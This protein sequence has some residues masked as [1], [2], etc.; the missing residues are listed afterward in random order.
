YA[1]ALSVAGIVAGC[2]PAWRPSEPGSG[3]ASQESA[4]REPHESLALVERFYA[5]GERTSWADGKEVASAE[6]IN[7]LPLDEGSVDIAYVEL[8]SPGSDPTWSTDL[9]AIDDRGQLL[10]AF[11]GV[12]PDRL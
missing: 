4:R 5:R 6:I 10:F 11:G 1:A 3:H 12:D 9:L 2:A 7:T 8:R